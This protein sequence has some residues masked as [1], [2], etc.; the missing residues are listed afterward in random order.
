MDALC[1]F[2]GCSLVFKTAKRLFY[3]NIT[4]LCVPFLSVLLHF[5]V[6]NFLVF[7]L[8]IWNIINKASK[9]FGAYVVET[10]TAQPRGKLTVICPFM[11]FPHPL[12]NSVPRVRIL[13]SLPSRE[14]QKN[15][16]AKNRAVAR[17]F[18]SRKLG[19]ENPRKWMPKRRFGFAAGTELS[20]NRISESTEGQRRKI[21]W[22]FFVG[23]HSRSRETSSQKA[24]GFFIFEGS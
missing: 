24:T 9:F 2:A 6:I 10:Q 4:P 16:W 21:R 14:N 19:F 22:P 11:F 12:Q 20:Q 5:L 7:A 13:L 17:F 15:I 23:I 18:A 1:F 8:R 3:A